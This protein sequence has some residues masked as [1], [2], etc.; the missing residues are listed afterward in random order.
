MQQQEQSK[1]EEM[2][3]FDAYA[4]HSPGEQFA[5][6]FAGL[7]APGIV[8]DAGCGSGKGAVA[9]E[10]RGFKVRMA[11]ITRAG[12]REE[13]SRIPFQQVCLWNRD[14]VARLKTLWAPDYVFCCDVMEH[15]PTQYTML[16]IDNLLSVAKAAFFSIS[17][18]PD[19]FGAWVGRPLH[20]TVQPFGWW[21]DQLQE[22]GRVVD[23]RDLGDT[24]TYL[25][26]AR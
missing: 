20:L 18:Q 2:W 15:I 10:A 4:D 23:A 3:A 12:L 5:E 14:Q 1:Y 22:F 24:G 6:L 26:E 7:V 19:Q 8:L 21:R 17:L 16:V 11:D 25:V 9:L 13:A